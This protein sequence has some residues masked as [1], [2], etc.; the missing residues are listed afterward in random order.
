MIFNSFTFIVFFIT[1]LIL[2]YTIPH[3][4][5]WIMLLLASYIFYMAWRPV[6]ILLILFSTLANFLIASQF[7]KVKNRK[8]LLILSIIINFGLLFIF[9]YSIFINHTFMNVFSALG[10]HYPINDFDIILPMGISFYTFQA[11]GYTFDVYNKRTKPIDNFFKFSL[12]ITFFPQLVAGPIE[13]T[14]DL[15][16]Q[17]FTEKKFKL[18]NLITGGKWMIFGFFKKIVIADR[19]A[20][21]VNTVYNSPHYFKGLSFIIA[22]VLFAFQIYCDFSGYSDIAKG[23]AKALDIELMENFKTP[24]FASSIKE[25]W[26]RWHISLSTWF[27][28]Y[29]YIPLGGSRVSK[30]RKYFNVMVTF[31]VSGLWHG[32]N[33]SFVIW[34]GLHGGLQVAEDIIKIKIPRFLSAI[35]TFILVCF[36]WIFF[37]AN[38]VRDSIYIASNLFNGS[39]LWGDNQYIYYV[40]NGLGL[41]LVELFIVVFCILLLMIIEFF[42]RKQNIHETL[43][44]KPLALRFAVYYLLCVLILTVGVFS[45][46]SAFIYFQF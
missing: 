43:N 45:S 19:V 11:A 3:R 30:L 37:R 6:L 21:A 4:F 25:F 44:R 8:L 24:Y 42:S 29:L 31:I 17:L 28:D 38:S 32:A 39:E 40:L 34:G 20:V 10:V 7:D 14:D 35:I 46:G 36:A 18:D 5:R 12:F 23:C 33:W 13:R 27:K 26:R 22:T 15:M 2:Y 16:P 1:V 9:K 41:Q